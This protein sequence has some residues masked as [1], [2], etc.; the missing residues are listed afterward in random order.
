MKNDAIRITQSEERD[1]AEMKGDRGERGRDRHRR[2]E[3]KRDWGERGRDRHRRTEMKG[4]WGERSKTDREMCSTS[5]HIL[6]YGDTLERQRHGKWG[7]FKRRIQGSVLSFTRPFISA[8]PSGLIG[9]SAAYGGILVLHD[10]PPV[11]QWRVT[12][13]CTGQ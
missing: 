10:T 3:M 8:S 2:T 7:R 6:A 5:N 11:E 13:Q 1:G 12:P 4:D 9:A